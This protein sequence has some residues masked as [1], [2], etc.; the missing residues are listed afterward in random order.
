MDKKTALVLLAPGFEDIEACIPI[1]YLRRAGVDVTTV[2]VGIKGKEV[3]GAN[4]ITILADKTLDQVSTILF[5]VIITPG[6]LPGATNL[7]ENSTVVD[8]IKKHYNEG[9]FIASICASPGVVLAEACDIVS[10]K[11]IC[12]YPGFEEE[13]TSH[14]GIISTEN[15]CVDG[16]LITARG[17]GLAID[18]AIAIVEQLCGKSKAQKLYDTTLVSK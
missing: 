12:G 7:A 2:S 1:D 8:L 14:N 17:P 6:G 5:D 13:I 3:T 16:K 15:V 11:K 10:G 4:E 18:F 9:R